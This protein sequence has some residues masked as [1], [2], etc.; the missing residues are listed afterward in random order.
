MAV[1][2]SLSFAIC[3][4]GTRMKGLAALLI[5]SVPSEVTDI[6]L[7]GGFFCLG[8]SLETWAWKEF[9]QVSCFGHR[10]ALG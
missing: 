4:F 7:F 9:L 2:E 10:G 1:G 6:V 5:S 3:H 8:S